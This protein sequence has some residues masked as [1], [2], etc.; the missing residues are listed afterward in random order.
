MEPW[1]AGKKNFK[2]AWQCCQLLSEILANGHLPQV[3]HQSC[4][5]AND[6][7]DNKMVPGAVHRSPGICLTAEENLS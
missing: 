2:L 7:G 3:S 4:L 1:A 6:E 5:S